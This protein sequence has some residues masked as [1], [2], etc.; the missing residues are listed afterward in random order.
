MDCAGQGAI[1]CT[2]QANT[3]LGALRVGGSLISGG[4][5][6]VPGSSTGELIRQRCNGTARRTVRAFSVCAKNP[7]QL[8]STPRAAQGSGPT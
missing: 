1:H 8:P 6:V 3:K 7:H 2:L 5:E 4:V